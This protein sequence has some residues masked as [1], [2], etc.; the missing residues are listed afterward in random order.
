MPGKAGNERPA[1]GWCWRC[2][3]GHLHLGM[4][5]VLLL[6]CGLCARWNRHTGEGPGHSCR[7]LEG[8]LGACHGVPGLFPGLW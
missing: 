4:E 1:V 3:Q 2:C 7:V 5:L 8:R 6:P